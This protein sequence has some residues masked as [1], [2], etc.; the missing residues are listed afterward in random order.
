M[1]IEKRSY[2]PHHWVDRIRDKDTGE[3]IQKGTPWCAKYMNHIELGIAE[4]YDLFNSIVD[5]GVLDH[6]SLGAL[7]TVYNG[8]LPTHNVDLIQHDFIEPDR[9][10]Y[11]EGLDLWLTTIEDPD[12][13]GISNEPVFGAPG[14]RMT[15]EQMKSWGMS[16]PI[17]RHTE[18]GKIILQMLNKPK[19][20]MPIIIDKIDYYKPNVDDIEAEPTNLTKEQIDK[21]YPQGKGPTVNTM[22]TFVE[23]LSK[24]AYED[25][26][27]RINLP[28]MKADDIIF[29]DNADDPEKVE[30]KAWRQAG[31]VI[32]SQEDE[33]LT[34][35]VTGKTIPQID[36]HAVFHVIKT[37]TEGEN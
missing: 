13:E 27:L 36:L 16:S 3:I 20:R 33:W 21:A 12:V 10:T 22:N 28:G 14:E 15:P 30:H 4:L 1:A 19:V 17:V 6:I 26:S 7:K 37:V 23:T 9:T 18:S 5:S 32:A 24:D 31:F 25:G 2:D 35:S 34:I 29:M 11:D 8:D